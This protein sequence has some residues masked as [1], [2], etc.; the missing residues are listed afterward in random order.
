M[1]SKNDKKGLTDDEVLEKTLEVIS[2]NL[3]NKIITIYK[4]DIQEMTLNLEVFKQ[5]SND[6]LE[7]VFVELLIVM[8]NKNLLDKF[9]S[10]KTLQFKEEINTLA[11]KL[12]EKSKREVFKIK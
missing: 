9:E 10:L 2:H 11:N 6:Q 12:I 7:L 8:E 5:L 3:N 4:A 1:N